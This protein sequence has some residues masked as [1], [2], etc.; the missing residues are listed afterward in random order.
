MKL[1]LEDGTEYSTIDNQVL[2]GA[3]AKLD[4]IDN[5][6]ALLMHSDEVYM[7]TAIQERGLYALEYRDESGKQYETAVM[8]TQGQVI[9]AFQK[10]ARG[11][12][13]WLRDFRWQPLNA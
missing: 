13:S 8:A 10:Y 11:D 3:L 12:R 1:K 9:T 5:S 2:A 4:G 6:F 7:Q